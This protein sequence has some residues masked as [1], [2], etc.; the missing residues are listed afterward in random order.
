[1]NRKRRSSW[2]SRVFSWLHTEPKNE[3]MLVHI[4][5]NAQT[6]GLIEFETLNMIEGVIQL[7]HMKARDIMMPKSHMVTVSQDATLEEAI[8][9]ITESG[10]SRFPVTTENKDEIIGILHAKDV[11]RFQKDD[12]ATFHVYDIARSAVFV[13]ESK[14]LDIL[15]HE[16]RNNKNH[17]ALVIDEYG[18]LSGFITIENI[19]EEI[20]GDIEDEFDIH[21]E[22]VIKK[23][24]NHYILRA[25]TPVSDFN[26]YFKA[27]FD[28]THADTIAG[29][30]IAH[31][32]YLPHFG[33][34]IE[35]S[36]F[37]FKII[38][39]DTRRLKLLACFDKRNLNESH[40]EL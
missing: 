7:A 31:A 15:L 22:D 23:H 35:I 37:Q 14:P 18:V 21:E 3:E 30:L 16:F 29:V 12:S 24:D 9:R 2:W 13:P 17:M 10:H 19:I 8:H 20:I 6:R 40:H 34:S 4:L 28:E 26:T 1:M 39:A 5:K 33:D 25:H 11:L 32:G 38:S 36:G 27:N